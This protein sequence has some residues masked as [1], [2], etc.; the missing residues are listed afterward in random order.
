MPASKRS[1][2][3]VGP[4]ATQDKSVVDNR[5]RRR[6]EIRIGGSLAGYSNYKRSPRTV[7]FTETVVEPRFRGR[8]VGSRLIAAAL[9]DAERR[10]LRIVPRCSFVQD[11]I[12]LQPDPPAVRSAV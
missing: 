6:Y 5:A 2:S 12:R 8:G 1:E 4:A 7:V 9:A 11:F 3:E 10:G